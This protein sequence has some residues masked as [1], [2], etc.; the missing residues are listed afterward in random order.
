MFWYVCWVTQALYEFLV[1]SLFCKILIL[2]FFH[3]K[4]NLSLFIQ[5]TGSKKLFIWP[6][7]QTKFV[8]TVVSCLYAIFKVSGWIT[9]A[10]L[11]LCIISQSQFLPQTI[12]QFNYLMLRKSMI[13]LWIFKFTP[14]KLELCKYDPSF[15]MGVKVIGN[16]ADHLKNLS[17]HI[18]VEKTIIYDT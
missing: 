9:L 5:A 10:L 8:S 1:F 18:W 6:L 17:W 7:L 14:K 16:R 12:I 2:F 3:Q 15:W 4:Q 11:F 13:R